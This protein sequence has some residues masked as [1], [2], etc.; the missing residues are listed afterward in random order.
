MI[1]VYSV[2]LLI[3]AMCAH[4]EE[5]PEKVVSPTLRAEM[6]KVVDVL[7]KDVPEEQKK[8]LPPGVKDFSEMREFV[9]KGFEPM[10]KVRAEEEK[11]FAKGEF[12]DAE[13]SRKMDEYVKS[14]TALK[15]DL[16]APTKIF[17]KEHQEKSLKGARLELAVRTSE[18][19]NAKIKAAMEK[20]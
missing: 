17:I 9:L 4:A 13:N 14:F 11:A 5:A 7:L 16:P 18:M 10:L 20:K 6:G 3:C 15:I 8:Q 1:R 12:N 19:V 2:L